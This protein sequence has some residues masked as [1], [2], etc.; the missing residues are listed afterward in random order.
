MAGKVSE[1]STDVPAWGEGPGFLPRVRLSE[2]GCGKF[3]TR[4]QSQGA[5]PPRRSFTDRCADTSPLTTCECHRAVRGQRRQAQVGGR[6]VRRP[7]LSPT[8]PMVTCTCRLCWLPPWTVTLTDDKLHKRAIVRLQ[9]K[10]QLANSRGKYCS[11]ETLHF[12]NLPAK[13]PEGKV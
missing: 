11:D 13:A 2:R 12:I 8:P 3:C 5:L 6:W 1:Q 4:S 10:S 9:E 7:P